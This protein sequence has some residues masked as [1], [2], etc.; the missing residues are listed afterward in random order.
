MRPEGHFTYSFAIFIVIVQ[1]MFGQLSWWDSM[2]AAS[3]IIGRHSLKENSLVFC[4]LVLSI[5]AKYNVLFFTSF[6]SRGSWVNTLLPQLLNCCGFK[7]WEQRELRVK[8]EKIN[9]GNILQLLS[10]LYS[11]TVSQ[12]EPK[13]HWWFSWISRL[14]SSRDHLVPSSPS[15]LEPESTSATQS[16]S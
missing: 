11:D 7:L 9:M 13:A 8:S 16:A 14:A 6:L 5:P 15:E 1:L 10:T 3:E 2:G 4:F 12:P